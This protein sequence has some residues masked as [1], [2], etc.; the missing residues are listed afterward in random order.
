MKN[1]TDSEMLSKRPQF[2]V[3]LPGRL[4]ERM[5]KELERQARKR[6]ILAARVF[7]HFLSLP[8]KERDEICSRAA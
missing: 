7:N 3:R 4:H 2:N 8:V 5:V 1:G 6:D